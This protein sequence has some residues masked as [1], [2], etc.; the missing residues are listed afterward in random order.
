[1]HEVDLAVPESGAASPVAFDGDQPA[2]ARLGTAFFALRT[3]ISM[4]RLRLQL[5]LAGQRMRGVLNQGNDHRQLLFN[6][7]QAHQDWQA[8][9]EAGRA[10]EG[11]WRD[12]SPHPSNQPTEPA[13]E[14]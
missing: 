3:L 13:T 14:V 4:Q 10:A 11:G 6:W 12:G 7:L 5:L 1:M 2:A 9:L 8:R